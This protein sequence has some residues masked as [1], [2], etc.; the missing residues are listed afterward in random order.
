[1]AR[2][3]AFP[4]GATMGEELPVLGQLQFLHGLVLKAL[5]TEVGT[6]AI[7]G[8]GLDGL[9][10]LVGLRRQ[11][12]ANRIGRTHLA[13]GEHDAH[14]ARLADQVALCI[15]VDAGRQKALL[16]AVELAAWGA[17][18]RDLNDALV[19]KVQPGA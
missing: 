19:P 5:A 1:M 13:A 15:V 17:Q 2:S 18:P 10:R 8:W 11:L 16:D 4:S 7:P 9:E 12:N 14:D 6:P 3:A